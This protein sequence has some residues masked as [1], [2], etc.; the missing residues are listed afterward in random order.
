MRFTRTSRSPRLEWTPRKLS[1]ALQRPHRRAQLEA[2]R[3]PLLAPLL[4]PTGDVDPDT[5]LQQRQA[6]AD[7]SEARMRQL[8]ARI[9][10]SARCEFFA[11]TE[12]QK[13]AI[14][15]AWAEWTGPTKAFYFQYVVELHTGVQDARSREFQQ[16]ERTALNE[17]RLR[18]TA[19]QPLF[20]SL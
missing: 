20:D 19:Q 16:R 6:R 15:K 18:V 7:V 1:I 5:E 13:E 10:R 11:A 14:R 2:D 17:I 8:E 12:P 3:L 9:W 4:P